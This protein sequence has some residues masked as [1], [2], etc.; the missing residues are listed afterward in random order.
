MMMFLFVVVVVVLEEE[1]DSSVFSSFLASLSAENGV[2]ISNPNRLWSRCLDI[3]LNREFARDGASLK[4][5]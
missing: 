5:S 1:D 3:R 2:L 4:D